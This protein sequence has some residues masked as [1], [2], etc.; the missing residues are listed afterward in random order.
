MN[1]MQQNVS[2]HRH[3][4]GAGRPVLLVPGWT[5]SINQQTAALLKVNGLRRQRISWLLNLACKLL[6]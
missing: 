3:R 5:V 6:L 4:G 2:I 1:N